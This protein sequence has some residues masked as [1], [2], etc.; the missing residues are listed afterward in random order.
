MLR[1][2][3]HASISF[4]AA[5]VGLSVATLVVPGM[6]IAWQSFLIVVLIFA[7][8]QSVL[9]PFIVRAAAKNAAGFVGAASLLSTVASLLLT[10]IWLDGLTTSGGMG[11][12]AYASVVVRITAMLVV[13][14]LHLLVI[15]R[16]VKAIRE[17]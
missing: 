9:G 11:A 17:T 10:S 2:L 14:L 5:G 3:L 8:L 7:V 15:K 16:G 6:S 4:G 12:W 13:L 1:A